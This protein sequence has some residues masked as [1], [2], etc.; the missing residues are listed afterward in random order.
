MAPI[1]QLARAWTLDQPEAGDELFAE[2]YHQLRLISVRQIRQLNEP[3]TIQATELV[4]EAYVRMAEQ[5]VGKWRNRAHFFGIAATVIRRVLL[6]HAR[7]RHAQCRDRHN[8]TR[9]DDHQPS[10][11]KSRA[12]ELIHL[13]EALNTLASFSHRQAKVVELR[14]FGGL[15]IQETSDVL[16]IAPATVKRDW[17]VAKTWL[18]RQLHV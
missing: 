14:Y 3:I 9:I 10:M 17:T 16:D 2:I 12:E 6:D 13:D 5:R 7:F 8:E 1:T 15:S 4:N 11:S 18:Y